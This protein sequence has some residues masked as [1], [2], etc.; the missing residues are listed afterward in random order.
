M[1]MKYITSC[2]TIIFAPSFNDELDCG[3]LNDYRQI[4]FSNYNLDDNLFERYVNNN[5]QGLK[6]IRSNF[7][8]SFD[9]LPSIVTYL[10]FG[11]PR[12]FTFLHYAFNFW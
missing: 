8:R 12:K 1:E 9:N 2:D 5:F 3:L 6:Y 7:N 10:T 11:L 4:I